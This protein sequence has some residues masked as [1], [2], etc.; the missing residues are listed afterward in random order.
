MLNSVL[1]NVVPLCNY[2]KSL[3]RQVVDLRKMMTIRDVARY[4]GVSQRSLGGHVMRPCQRI[5]N[6]ALHWFT[7]AHRSTPSRHC[8]RHEKLPLGEPGFAILTKKQVAELLQ[9]SARQVEILV[10]KG[11]LPSTVYLG[12]SSPRWKLSEIEA[13]FDAAPRE[14]RTGGS[15]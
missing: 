14:R 5:R 10:K 1:P 13:V 9:C 2:T 3:A 6:H 7:K 4:V 12:D 15:D 8:T 11:Q